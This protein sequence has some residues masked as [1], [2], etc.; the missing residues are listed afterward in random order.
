MN[1][2][3]TI[4]RE[5]RSGNGLK[6]RGLGGRPVRVL[7]AALAALIIPLIVPVRAFAGDLNSA[8]QGILSAIAEKQEY[9]GAYYKVT[10]GY[11]AKVTEYLSRDGIDMSQRE[12][13]DYIAQF[14]ANISVGIASGY[15]EKVGGGEAADPG[16]QAGDGA[17]ADGNADTGADNQ[18]GAE[19]E[20]D[21][22]GS[23]AGTGATA[24]LGTDPEGDGPIVDNTMGSTSEGAVEY[25]VLPMD[26]E[27]M[28]VQ[29]I[30]ELDVHEE[31]YKDSA[32]IGEIKEGEPVKVTGAAS[33]GWAQ[34]AFGEKTG[35]VSA[36]Y[37]RT[38][39]YMDKK[40]AEKKAEEEAKRQAEEEARKAEEAKKAEEEA[41]KA[42]EAK[43]AEE[44]AAAAE[45]SAEQEKDY[46][47]AQPVEKSINLGMIAVGI[48]VVCIAALGGVL[49]YHN[50]K[51]RSGKR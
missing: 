48:V 23:A 36:A 18:T 4:R 42:E 51:S 46:S 13:D 20:N 11:I 38:Q 5:D 10:D 6:G 8:E 1:G 21:G 12:A 49:F 37:L 32:V 47:N 24:G 19:A 7:A 29:G 34:I 22:N 40:E 9:E 50:K 27:T 17:D 39:G 41:R 45:A 3:I 44:E 26:E 25:V 43:K 16:T 33:T 15:M 30:E 31:A 28:Y 35:Y 14:R 2:K